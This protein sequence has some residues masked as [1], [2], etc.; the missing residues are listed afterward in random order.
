MTAFLHNVL[1]N[2][3]YMYLV[4]ALPLHTHPFFCTAVPSCSF[5][6]KQA[7]NKNMLSRLRETSACWLCLLRLLQTSEPFLLAKKLLV[8]RL[9]RLFYEDTA[10]PLATLRTP[11]H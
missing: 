2:T 10:L 5:E 8:R 6:R 9:F 4:Y 1:C 11:F 3:K 7:G